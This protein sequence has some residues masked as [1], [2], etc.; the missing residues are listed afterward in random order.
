MKF[1]FESEKFRHS[2]VA[3]SA[4]LFDLKLWAENLNFPETN[5]TNLL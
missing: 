5:Q 2:R 4:A 3:F 1:A